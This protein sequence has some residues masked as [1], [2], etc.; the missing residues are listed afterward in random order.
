LRALARKRLA[1]AHVVHREGMTSTALEMIVGALL[2]HVAAVAGL[3]DVLNP[4]RAALWFYGEAVPKGWATAEVAGEILKAQGLAHAP[5][6]PHGL[7]LDML[8]TASG[9]TTPPHEDLPEDGDGRQDAE[10]HIAATRVRSAFAGP[11]K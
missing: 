9:V 6:V 8:A 11:P 1:A 4:Q 7:V 10:R 3:T 2:A 5:A